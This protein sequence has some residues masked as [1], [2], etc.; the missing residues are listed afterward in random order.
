VYHQYTITVADGKRD[1]LAAHLASKGIGSGLYY[2]QPLHSQKVYEAVGHP[3]AN[4]PVTEKITK[5]ALSIP[6][7]PSVTS[8]QVH[9]VAD[10]IK[11]F[12]K[13]H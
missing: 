1:A 13:T 7:H 4:C 9:F 12:A 10:A 11:E 8:E 3:K 2:P 5:E 6:V